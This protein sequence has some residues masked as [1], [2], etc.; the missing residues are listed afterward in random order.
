MKTVNILGLSLILS[1]SAIANSVNDTDIQAG[2]RKAGLCAGCHGLDGISLSD[3]YP[4]LA[5]QK[6]RY[7]ITQLNQ[8]KSQ[9][10]KSPTMNII[11]LDL[12]DDSI[13]LLA[14]YY[15]NIQPNPISTVN[16]AAVAKTDNTQP[17]K[18]AFPTPVYI[19]LK[20]Q[21]A[22]TQLPSLKTKAGAENMLYNAITADGKT[23][24]ATSPSTNTVLV[25]KTGRIEQPKHISVGQQPKG[26][27]ISP[28]GQYAYV[29]NQGSNNI[30]V[31]HLKTLTVT[32]TIK[33][34]TEPHNVRFTKDGKTA[35]VTLQGGAG[36]GVID[37]TKQRQTKVIPVPG[38]TGPH[39]L[40]LSQ[41]EKIAFVR[42]FIHHVA[43]VDLQSGETLKVIKVGNGHGGIDVAPN[44][45]YVS[46]AAIGDDHIT[47]IDTQT[48]DATPVKVG[49]GP[50]GIR[51]SSDSQWIYVTVTKDNR[52][53]VINAKTLKVE[54]TLKTGAFPFWISV[55]NNP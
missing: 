38:I 19:S 37:T 1:T 34:D 49:N 24:L 54:N 10:R 51:Y 30:S 14:T 52:V 25:F 28:D 26:V 15:S 11:A 16:V 6:K 18:Q 53:V 2:K 27:K 5:G 4:N 13:E 44:G 20:K 23:L 48:L 47:V 9:Y 36:I 31:I 3:E 42:D 8:F 21:G 29:S 40:D 22:I 12:T 50:H 7:L 43:V 32:N 35:Y 45:K 55:P 17:T 33:T 41:D 39:N 46:T